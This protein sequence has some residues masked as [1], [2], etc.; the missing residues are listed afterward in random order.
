VASAKSKIYGHRSV[1]WEGSQRENHGSGRQFLNQPSV[2]TFSTN[3]Q[4]RGK[5]SNCVFCKGDHYN[6][7]CDG[8]KTL[9]ERKQKL[10]SCFPC[11][12]VGHT[13]FD[14]SSP[15]RSGCLYCGKENSITIE[16][17]AHKSLVM[18]K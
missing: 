5:S 12:K 15:Q 9:A 8:V 13:F 11:F 16:L 3:V 17:S 2:D 1:R 18:V 4:R 7:E 14:Y 6:D 10:I